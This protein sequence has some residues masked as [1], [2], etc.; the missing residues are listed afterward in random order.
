MPAT[1]TLATTTL[2]NQVGPS[3]S[4]VLVASVTGILAGM[5]LYV[6]TES[7]QVLSFGPVS[8]IVNVKRGVD[9]T[10][11]STH[12]SSSTVWIATGDQLY[13]QNP[14]GAPPVAVLVLPWI[15]VLTGEIWYPYGDEA[16]TPSLRWW[17]KETVTQGVGSLGVRTTTTV[18]AQ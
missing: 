17:Q 18:G 7:M 13:T 10:S 12:S 15:N 14:V 1:Y 4:S 11:A 6:D 8:G 2:V 3:D 16:A 5:R 9:G